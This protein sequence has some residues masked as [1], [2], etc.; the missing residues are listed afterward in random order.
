MFTA[1]RPLLAIISLLALLAAACG[2]GNEAQPSSSTASPSP[3]PSLSSSPVAESEPLKVV[4]SALEALSRG[5]V[6][7]AYANLSKDARQTVGLAQVRAIVN[8]LK[9]AGTP[10]SVTIE[11]VGEQA[12]TGNMAEIEFTLGV[13]IGQTSVPVDDVASLVR[14]D[15]QWRIADHFLQT[16]LG[17]VGLVKPTPGQRQLDADGCAAADPLLGVYAPARLKVLDP[18]V[19]VTGTVR[20]DITHASDGDI[21]FGLEVSGDDR[22]L[23]NEGNIKNQGGTLHIEIVPLDQGRVP[24]PK[25]GDRVRVTGPWVTDT[26][27][28]HNEIHPAF[29]IEPVTQ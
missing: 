15:G 2:G 4:R 14:E 20:D 23:L 9:S 28:G 19:T 5:D 6:D 7:S 17:A 10:L 16:A 22:R 25:P 24:A 8:A 27:H 26:V 12:V 29:L 18:C 1:V 3:S 13:Q 21:T 11:R